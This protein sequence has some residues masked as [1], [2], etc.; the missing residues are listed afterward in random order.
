MTQSPKLTRRASRQFPTSLDYCWLCVCTICGAEPQG[1]GKGREGRWM[2]CSTSQPWPMLH[3][4]IWLLLE[5]ALLQV[6]LLCQVC[7]SCD[8]PEKEC[9]W[10]A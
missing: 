8:P 9:H 6:F 5:H 3:M 7:Q 2:L 4:H 1:G 10:N